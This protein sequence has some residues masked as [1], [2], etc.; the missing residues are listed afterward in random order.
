VLDN[1]TTLVVVAAVA[2]T[3]CATPLRYYFHPDADLGT[4]KKVAV[5]PFENLSSDQTVGDKVQRLFTLELLSLGAFD[6]VEPGLVGKVMR[7]QHVEAAQNM[8]PDDIKQLGK[9]LE[10]QGLF[11]GTVV[12][13]KDDRVG[14]AHAPEVT[15][16][17]RLVEA[18]TGV[19]IWSCTA[20]QSGAALSVRLFGIGGDSPTEAAQA[21]MRRQLRTLVQ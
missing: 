19:T 15:L 21:L 9:A 4:V 1:R 16:Q 14:T 17:L 10:V 7:T 11:F 13:F 6:V 5:L 20:S 12:E 2:L 8:T 18:A 3:G